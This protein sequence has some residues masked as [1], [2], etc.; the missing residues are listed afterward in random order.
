MLFRSKKTL[1]WF[2]CLT[3]YITK[4]DLRS[5]YDTEDK[6]NDMWNYLGLVDGSTGYLCEVANQTS[7]EN[8]IKLINLAHKLADEY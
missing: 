1:D 5:V 2:T 6:V 4:Q 8:M 3:T 7:D